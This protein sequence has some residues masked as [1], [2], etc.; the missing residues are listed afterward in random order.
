MIPSCER[1]VNIEKDDL[2]RERVR[3]S[4]TRA[5]KTQSKPSLTTSVIYNELI[6]G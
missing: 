3:E 4:Y 5:A 1:W 2:R 6:L